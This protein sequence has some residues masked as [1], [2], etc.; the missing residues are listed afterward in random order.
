[1]LYRLMMSGSLSA[2]ECNILIGV[3]SGS[4]VGYDA[5]CNISLGIAGRS[6]S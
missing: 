1:M 5:Q 6:N 3:Y 4:E 2:K